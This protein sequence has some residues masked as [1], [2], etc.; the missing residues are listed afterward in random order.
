MNRMAQWWRRG[1]AAWFAC[2]LGTGLLAAAGSAR[3]VDEKDLL[4]VDQAFALEA[5]AP[6]PGRVQLQ[7]RIAEGYYLYRHRIAVQA[8]DGTPLGTLQ[9]PAGDRHTDPF[10]GE[11]ETYR[12]LLRATLPLQAAGDHVT[13]QVKYQGCA[14]AGVCYPPQ[15]RTLVVA[16]APGG[17]AASAPATASPGASGGGNDLA[18]LAR[19][20]GGARAGGAV[21]ARPLPAEQAF[22][23]EAIAGDGN[24]VLL[25][26]TPARGYYLYRDRTTLRLRDA[27]G[28]TLGTPRWP[29]GMPHRDAHFGDVV[30]YFDQVDVPVPLS[31]TRAAPTTATVVATF[32][33]CQAD[34]ICYPPMTRS[35]RVALP[36]GRIGPA[37]AS[38]ASSA[39]GAAPLAPAGTAAGAGVAPVAASSGVAA[40]QP[41]E[42]AGQAGGNAPAG[43]ARLGIAG[44]LLA[45]LLGGLVL[46]LMP[47]VL[48]V[49]SLKA[50]SLVGH[51]DD[52]G[53]ARR[54]A[55]WYTAGVLL[56]F[57]LLG[58]LALGLR[59]A[60]LALGWGFQLQQPRVVAVL[61]L[62]M[63]ALGL[64]LS[65]VWHA[66]GA[67]TGV[68]DGL[69][70]R[71]GPAGDF[72]TGVLAVVVATPCTA[73]FMG[74]A[75]A[76]AFTAPAAL[77]LAVF[78]VL[79]I[80][81][82]LP[83]LLLG[84]SPRLVRFLPRPGAWMDT[85]KQ[86]LAFPLYLTAAW[87]AWVL[88]RQ[89][90][91][92][93]IAWW[94]VAAVAIAFVAW[95]WGHARSGRSRWAGVA[96]LLAM[97]AVA[98]PLARIHALPRPQA[99]APAANAAA[100]APV[101][102]SGQRLADLR[103]AHRVVFVNVT[104]DWCVTC[105]ANERTVFSQAGF[106]EAMARAGAV[107]MVG[108]WTDV[109][110]ALTAFLQRHGAVGVPLYVVYPADGG[111][112]QVLPTVLTLDRVREALR[113]AAGGAG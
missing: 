75:L 18:G 71:T 15:K 23:F 80:G 22:G 77:A 112:G 58:A 30:V 111:P 96:A 39:T 66:G 7:W 34:G 42:R 85:L 97:L 68:G 2:A 35:V 87:L 108:D 86:V 43:R 81:L 44:A 10:F 36:A 64:S 73:P 107:Y 25:R 62:V 19:A 8:T 110:P 37:A 14:D 27:D 16:L 82:A 20:L 70:R 4:P 40:A 48:P 105:K 50:M 5:G 90:G 3:A 113:T 26:F 92:D 51:G 57:L 102:F 63:L 17:A 79:G 74:A 56:S 28:I 65:G 103:A 106:R 98:L 76:W 24:T 49:L 91:V 101:A 32:Q 54:H 1:L 38:P 99:A 104:A 94:L 12:H 69:A 47:C 33:G 52:A 67:W 93:A 31:R 83:F 88:G 100:D 13:L 46:N 59:Q 45:A 29:P 89:R 60:G 6:A 84:L 41:A 21:D 61:G 72:F 11:V 53:R 78:L 55:L 9:L 109:D 95:A